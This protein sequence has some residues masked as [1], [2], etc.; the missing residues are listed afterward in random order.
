MTDSNP[1]SF[2]GV[3]GDEAVTV[4]SG[5]QVPLAPCFITLP[6]PQ[7]IEVTMIPAA[8]GT[9]G[10]IC[11]DPPQSI[12]QMEILVQRLIPRGWV[13][14]PTVWPW[15]RAF[16]CRVGALLQPELA[17]RFFLGFPTP[18]HDKEGARP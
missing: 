17:A 18:D 13:S 9:I 2:C 10:G 14:T 12:R 4:H 6:P 16:F 15:R 7:A 5:G 11:F 1:L 8:D 3:R